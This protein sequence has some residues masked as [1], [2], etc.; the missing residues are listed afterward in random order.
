MNV[1]DLRELLE[2]ALQT[3]K[4]DKTDLSK[5]SGIK[6]RQKSGK[7]VKY[8]AKQFKS[9][10]RYRN[11]ESVFVASAGNPKEFLHDISILKV[12]REQSPEELALIARILDVEW[13]VEIEMSDRAT[14]FM[15]DLN[16]LGAGTQ[17][18]NKMYVVQHCWLQIDSKQRWAIDQVSKIAQLQNGRFY[19]AFI[20]HPRDWDSANVVQSVKVQEIPF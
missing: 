1:E 11:D 19:L 20:P 18:S 12:V 3:A 8:L 17:T 7:F 15:E 2:N 10:T 6:H 16:K 5:K 9:C 14:K 13:Q 4:Q